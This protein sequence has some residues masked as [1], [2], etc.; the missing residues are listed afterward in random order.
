MPCMIPGTRDEARWFRSA[1]RR[2][3]PASALDWIVQAALPRRRVLEVQPLADGLR[4]ANFKLQTDS[5]PEWIV[6]RLYEHD[7]SL[8]QKELDVMSL[9]GRSVP[10]PE[11]LHAEPRGL[12]EI[13]PFIVMRYVEG[14]SFHQLKRGGDQNAMAQA[15]Y[16]AGET[17]AAIGHFTFPKAGWLGPGPA[18]TAPLLDGADPMPRFVDRCLASANLQQR[19]PAD[20]QDRIQAL[21]WSR[22]AQLA[23]LG[24]EARLVHGDF[25]RRNLVL[26]CKAGRWSVAAVL[27]WEFAVS[28]SPLADIGNF[29]RYERASQPLAEPHFSTGY[30][31]AGGILPEDW[32]NLARLIALNAMCESLTRDELPDDVVSELVE[33]A[34]AI[35]E[36]RDPQFA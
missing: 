32:R 16:A 23:T 25:N 12:D 17:L 4:N 21:M 24:N 15:A 3:L 30:L 29:L 19:V 28:G 27:D 34:R 5:K 10:T 13:P 35:V 33:L 9:V 36:R 14:V 18:V 20:V 11:I 1:P 2:T 8:C 26:R 22:A 31:H 6:L 7:A